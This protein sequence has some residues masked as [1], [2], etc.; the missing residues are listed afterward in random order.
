M[1]VLQTSGGGAKA[2]SAG[3]DRAARSAHLIAVESAQTSQ[4]GDV[5]EIAGK[6]RR[7]G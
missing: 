1:E 3:R 6:A 5:E 4:L 7:E 2:G